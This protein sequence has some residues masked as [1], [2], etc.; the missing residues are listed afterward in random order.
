LARGSRTSKVSSFAAASAKWKGMN[1]KNYERKNGLL[2]GE[3]VK[4]Q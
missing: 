4:G 3:K 2:E 1:G